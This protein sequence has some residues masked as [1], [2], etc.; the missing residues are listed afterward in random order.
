MDF[1]INLKE[2][3]LERVKNLILELD[4]EKS[5]ILDVVIVISQ[6]SLFNLDGKYME[7]I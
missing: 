3:R 5:L 4:L 6:N 1:K 2:A 7:L